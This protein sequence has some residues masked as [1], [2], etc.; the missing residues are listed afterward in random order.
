M[1][2][3]VAVAA[4]AEYIVTF[5]RRH[6]RGSEQFGLKI[7]TPREFLLQIGVLL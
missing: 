5:N 3:E 2:L 4:G 1:V 6:F 7:V